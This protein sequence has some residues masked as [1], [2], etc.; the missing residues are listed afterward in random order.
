MVVVTIKETDIIIEWKSMCFE[1]FPSNIADPSK[2]KLEYPKNHGF[3]SKCGNKLANYN[4]AEK[5]YKNP[6]D[7]FGDNFFDNLYACM[8]TDFESVKTII[9]I[10]NKKIRKF[11]RCPIYDAD[12]SEHL[13]TPV[14]DLT[15]IDINLEISQFERQSKKEINMLINNTEPDAVKVVWG[16]VEYSV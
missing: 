4:V 2:L 12:Y 8:N 13:A 10:P 16:T 15:N 1:C 7:D 3:C 6:I 9:L 5:G 14:R 11:N